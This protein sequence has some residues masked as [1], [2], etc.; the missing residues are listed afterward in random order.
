[1][2]RHRT[3]K[4]QVALDEYATRIGMGIVKLTNTDI[5]GLP[6]RLYLDRGRT[7]W[8]EIKSDTAYGKEGLSKSQMMFRATLAKYGIPLHVIRTENDLLKLKNG[9]LK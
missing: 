7:F 5:N 2:P 3:D 6:D 4:N 8:C 9:E 1:M